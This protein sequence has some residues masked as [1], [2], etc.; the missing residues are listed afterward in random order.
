M[1]ESFGNKVRIKSTPETEKIGLAGKIGDVFGET[2]PSITEIEVIGNPEKDYAINVYF[3]DLKDSYWFDEELIE[4]IDHGIGS[5]ITL[6]GVDKKW[7]KDSNGN[8]IE[9]NTNPNNEK[10]WWKFWKSK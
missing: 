4:T 10:K 8:W 6:D 2:K 7:I 1:F 9:E 5:V 3:E